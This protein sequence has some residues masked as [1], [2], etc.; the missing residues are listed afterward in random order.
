[1]QITFKQKRTLRLLVNFLALGGLFG[2]AI[3]L[4]LTK[5]IT[6][7]TLFRGFSMGFVISFLSLLGNHTFLKRFRKLPFPVF[8]L[9]KTSYFTLIGVLIFGLRVFVGP[10][11][12]KF[13]DQRELITIVVVFSLTI[14][15][16]F[17]LSIMIQRMIGQHGLSNFFL[18]KYHHPKE[19]ERIFMFLDIVSS[20]AVAERIGHIKFH[21][22]LNEV[23]IDITDAILTNAGSIYK[24][25]G[26]E[27]IIN[28]KLKEGLKNNHCLELYFKVKEKLEENKA[29]YL[30]KYDTFPKFRAGVHSGKVIVGEL[31]DI[32][33]EIAFLGDTVNTTARIQQACKTYEKDLLISRYLFEK[34]ELGDEYTYETLGDIQLKGK[35]HKLELISIQKKD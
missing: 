1:M 25:V 18:G 16:F 27:V 5:T 33:R 14:S 35:E 20:T 7:M 11:A 31:G 26:D 22:F 19:E 10:D 9:L 30:K 15:L 23:F 34:L 4:T 24:Y 32:K 21:K 29:S 12:P 6:W 28:W 2:I 8:I 3:T 17:N 13:F